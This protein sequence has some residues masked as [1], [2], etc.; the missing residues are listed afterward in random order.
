[1]RHRAVGTRLPPI[2]R[3]R[4]PSRIIDDQNIKIIITPSQQQA[5]L[6]LEKFRRT[7]DRYNNREAMSSQH[8]SPLKPRYAL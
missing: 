4:P 8:S 3:P 6:W 2:A 7:D 5:D 1:V